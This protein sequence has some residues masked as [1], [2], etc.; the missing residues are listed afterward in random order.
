[1][2]TATVTLLAPRHPDFPHGTVEGFHAKCH[3]DLC[4]DAIDASRSAVEAERL[5]KAE[6]LPR[7][8]DRKGREPT[9]KRTDYDAED[10]PHGTTGHR[11][12]C[13]CQVCVGKNSEY[14]ADWRERKGLHKGG[15]RED[16][17]RDW[18]QN[19]PKKEDSDAT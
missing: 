19:Q 14:R 4:M 11:Y 8:R 2:D 9:K 18:A 3:C 16:Y 17:W 10:F 12:G 7:I 6:P 13:R 15:A 1:M 5:N